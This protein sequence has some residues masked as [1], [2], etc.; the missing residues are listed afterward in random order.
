MD[1][2]RSEFQNDQ[3]KVLLDLK[4]RGH[5]KTGRLGRQGSKVQHLVESLRT[6]KEGDPILPVSLI[7][8]GYTPLTVHQALTRME[9]V[10]EV[11]RVLR[12]V[13]ERRTV[14]EFDINEG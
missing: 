8:R 1:R 13:Y 12:G 3:F 2:K 4:K 14:T 7:A 11:K 10:G 9:I 6:L 5:L